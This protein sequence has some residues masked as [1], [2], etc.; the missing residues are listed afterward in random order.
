MT[1]Y[2]SWPGDPRYLAGDDGSVVGPRGRALKA[3]ITDTGYK[4][5]HTCT[6]G[7]RLARTVH[8]MVCEAWHGVR[9]DG[10]EVAHDNGDRMD[11]RPANLSWKTRSDNHADKIRHGT[12]QR[13]ETANNR[14]LTEPQ[15]RDIR[16][17]HAA[18][19]SCY[20]IARDIKM[21][22]SNISRIVQRKAWKH[23]P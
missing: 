9:P 22:L 11:C 20:V 18:G 6:G 19:Q 12:A 10:M 8:I 13:G 2:R 15:V 4:Q 16:A 17:R 3:W 23:V 21:S 14:K 7:V 5:I 1:E